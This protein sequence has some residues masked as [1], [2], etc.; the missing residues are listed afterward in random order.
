MVK[1]AFF[2]DSNTPLFYINYQLPQGS[3]IRATAHDMS[4]IDTII[5]DK[6]GVISVASFIG[7]GASRFMLTYAPEQPN[8]AYGQFIIRAASLEQIAPLAAE[9]KRELS[10]AYPN[11]DIRT[12]RLVFGSDVGAKIEAIPLPT[13]YRLQWG[14]EYESSTDAQSAACGQYCSPQARQ[15]S[16]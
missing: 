10:E 6:P 14:G 13:G 5:R 8:N 2:P 12:E 3:D 15:Y 7:R 16:G 4:E 1:Q 9:L 11:A